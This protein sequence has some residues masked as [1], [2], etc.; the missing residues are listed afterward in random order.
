MALASFKPTIWSAALQA[1]L[2][3]N[4]VAARLTSAAYEGDAARGTTV[5]ITKITAPTVSDY[6]GSISDEAAA[7]TTIDL[8]I[9]EAKAFAVK[10]DDVE[11]AQAAAPVLAEITARGAY[12]LRDAIDAAV[13][14]AMIAGAAGGNAVVIDGAE[15]YKGLVDLSTKLTI[16]K[17]PM[18]GRFALVAPDMAGALA[19]DARM[20]RATAAGDAVVA[21][22][23]VGQAAGFDVYVS[24]NVP[25]GK[26]VAGHANGVATV[27]QVSKV[28]AVR[29]GSA[30]A[31]VVRAL[32]VFGCKVT[33]PGALAVGTLD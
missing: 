25:A 20:T 8:L 2:E 9:N 6:E 29:S 21:T 1:N 33:E 13:I 26:I 17:A 19:L 3:K 31:D 7:S 32:V 14:T 5:K 28:E 12:E 22:G 18:S 11:A 16:A 15:A 24:H 30:F 4:L 27:T 10:L 23:M